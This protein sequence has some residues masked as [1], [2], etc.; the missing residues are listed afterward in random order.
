MCCAVRRSSGRLGMGVVDLFVGTAQACAHASFYSW[1]PCPRGGQALIESEMAQ[2][3]QREATV[4]AM[5]PCELLQ[6]KPSDCEGL[7]IDL[8]GVRTFIIVQMLQRARPPAPVRG[9]RAP[10]DPCGAVTACVIVPP[11]PN[12][13]TPSAASVGM[14]AMRRGASGYVVRPSAPAAFSRTAALTMR[15]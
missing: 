12:D 9:A 15:S 1:R 7:P 3:L 11:K 10:C 2:H 6:I 4:S 14:L 8:A 13:E 5:Q